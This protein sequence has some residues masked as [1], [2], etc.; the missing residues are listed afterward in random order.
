MSTGL[1]EYAETLLSLADSIGLAG[2]SVDISAIHKMTTEDLLK[3]CANNNIR[4]RFCARG[5]K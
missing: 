1:K 4:F 3:M 2:G 5:D